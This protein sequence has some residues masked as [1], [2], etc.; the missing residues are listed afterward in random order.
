[1][2]ERTAAATPRA[3]AIVHDGSLLDYAAAC[4]AAAR[5]G[6]GLHRRGIGRGDRVAVLSPNTPGFFH[7]YFATD[8]CGAILVPLNTR[9]LEPE[10]REVLRDSG[11]RLVFADPGLA[12]QAAAIARPLGLDV[13]TFDAVAADAG[14]STFR[15][16]PGDAGTVAHLYYTS[17]TTGR[18][19][20]VML[21]HRNVVTHVH[22]AIA[23]LGL[24]AADRWAHIA[25]MFHLADAWAT[26]AITA[27]G[28]TH[29]FLERFTAGAALDLL[30]HERITITNLVPTMLNLMVNEPSAAA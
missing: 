16:D 7:A 3:P 6:A 23:E 4:A 9:L 18:P 24:C 26:F 25:P 8:G 20:G 29:L 28:G 10:Q 22:A 15:P 30:E 19:K 17:G 12:D 2:L 11:A 21:T 1:M 13:A 5:L 27:A 14:T